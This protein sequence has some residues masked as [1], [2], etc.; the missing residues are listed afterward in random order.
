MARYFKTK[1]ASRRFK[2]GDLA[3]QFEPVEQVGGSWLGLL[4]VDSESAA[5]SLAEARFPQISEITFEEFE[6]L[7]KKP[8]SLPQSY[9]EPRPPEPSSPPALAVAPASQ[10]STPSSDELTGGTLLY[11]DAEPPIELPDSAA[12]HT[13]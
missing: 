5:N 7:K 3:F 6:S 13:V 11:G 4:A 10:A 2:A 12:K 9:R 8:K 1:N